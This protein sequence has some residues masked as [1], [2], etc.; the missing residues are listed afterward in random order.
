MI[1]RHSRK[2]LFDATRRQLGLRCN[3]DFE[4][5][6][7]SPPLAPYEQEVEKGRLAV[8]AEYQE[9]RK[10]WRRRLGLPLIIGGTI[11]AGVAVGYLVR[12]REQPKA[13][14]NTGRTS[15]WTQVLCSVQALTPLWIALHFAPR[16]QAATVPQ[17]NGGEK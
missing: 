14:L 6:D 5:I 2:P 17:P 15:A 13:R 11:L 1:L 9:V 16:P 4:V 7:G 8:Y 3:L 12:G 10:S